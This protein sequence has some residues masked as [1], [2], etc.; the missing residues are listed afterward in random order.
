MYIRGA[1]MTR[2][3]VEQTPSFE[4]VEECVSE[5]LDEARLGLDDVGAVFLSSTESAGNSERQ[6]HTSPMISSLFQKKIP[7]VNMP[8]GCGGGGVALWNALQFLRTTSHEHVMVLGVDKVVGNTSERLTDEILMGGDRLY[9]QSEGMVFPAQNA[10]VAQ[11]YMLR[12]GAT[13]NDFALVAL[14]NHE[15]GFL[16]PKARFYGKRI[17]MEAIVKSPVVASPL[18]LFDCSISC[19]GAAAVIVSKQK[20]DVEI[21]GS[22]MSTSNLS[23]FERKDPISWEAT[24]VAARG[25]YAQAG[26][27]P[28]E[29]DFAEIHDAFTPVELI[30]YEDLGLCKQGEGI[31]LIRDGKTSLNGQIPVNTSGGLKARGHPISPTGIAQV[32]EIVRQMKGECGKRQLDRPKIGLAQNIGGAGSM[33]AVHVLRNHG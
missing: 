7:I 22:A 5:A 23:A 17:T 26:I 20:S 3:D 33:V 16:N 6:R 2:F 25:A 28:D 30:S 24:K 11:Q 27:R 18:R 19:N 12:C 4:R 14:K 8:W 9:E 29:I 21:V 32:Y 15:N 10:L 13:E 31:S 1:G